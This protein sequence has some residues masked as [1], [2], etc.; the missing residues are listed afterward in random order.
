MFHVPGFIDGPS[1]DQNQQITLYEK[2]INPIRCR[3][4]ENI[5]IGGDFNCQLSASDKFGGKDVQAQ[6]AVIRFIEKLCNNY[7]LVDAWREQHPHETRFTW[8]NSS[9]KIKCRLDFWLISKRLLS[10]VTKSDICAY[11]DSDHSQSPFLLN[12]REIMKKEVQAIGNLIILFWKAKILLQN[13]LY[14]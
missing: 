1:N 4:T 8:R 6:K 3:Q 9:K 11:C 13:E 7:S 12:Q 10:R 2:M 5:L 14:Y